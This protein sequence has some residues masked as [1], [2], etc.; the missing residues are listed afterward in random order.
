MSFSHL[1]KNLENILLLLKNE[2]NSLSEENIK[3]LLSKK[4]KKILKIDFPK[5][6]LKELVKMKYLLV[7]TDGKYSLTMKANS[8]FTN[9]K[10]EKNRLAQVE[11]NMEI[12]R[13]ALR[14]SE[15]S[16][17]ESTRANIIAII[18][19]LVAIIALFKK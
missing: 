11:E 10:Y 5:N 19:L 8:Y 9:L 1:P 16:S 18:A 12:S 7:D 6:E 3:L 4:T 2:K 15:R 13:R 14:A 17:K